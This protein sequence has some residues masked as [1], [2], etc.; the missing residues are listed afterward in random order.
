MDF[1]RKTLSSSREIIIDP[2][3]AG[4]FWCSEEKSE[5]VASHI[6]EQKIYVLLTIS[7]TRENA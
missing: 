7:C 6:L 1:F 3:P 4:V 2:V 5:N